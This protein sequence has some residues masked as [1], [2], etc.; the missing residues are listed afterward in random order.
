MQLLFLIY[1]DWPGIIVTQSQDV[2]NTVRT[3]ACE[4]AAG[5]CHPYAERGSERERQARVMMSPSP[6]NKLGLTLWGPWRKGKGMEWECAVAMLRDN[7]HRRW[8][9][10][11]MLGEGGGQAPWNLCEGWRAEDPEPP[12][13]PAKDQ[14]FQTA[15]SAWHDTPGFFTDPRGKTTFQALRFVSSWCLFQM[16]NRAVTMK[17]SQRAC[18]PVSEHSP[19]K[20]FFLFL[21][22]YPWRQTTKGCAI[23][24]LLK[25]KA[26]FEYS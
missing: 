24:F 3:A 16:Q 1:S 9:A 17:T 22:F 25:G 14:R 26:W 8:E 19:K 18:R 23:F 10:V 20:R 12:A 4:W 7:I 2:W 15:M 11:V 6:A 13:S 5:L 21:F